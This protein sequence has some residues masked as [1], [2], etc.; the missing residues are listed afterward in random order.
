VIDPIH[1]VVI[2]HAQDII[3]SD[4]LEVS[5]DPGDMDRPGFWATH[6]KI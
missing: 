2:F 1:D 4:L 6:P 5:H 3:A